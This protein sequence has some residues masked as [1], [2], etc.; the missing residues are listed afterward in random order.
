MRARMAYG[1]QLKHLGIEG[2]LPIDSILRDADM[3]S[4]WTE[5]LEDYAESR[6][7]WRE[8]LLANRR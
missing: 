5:L 8:V 2:L 6:G 1:T 7:P 3:Q 4:L